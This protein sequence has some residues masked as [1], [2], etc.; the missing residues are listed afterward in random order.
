MKRVPREYTVQDHLDAARDF[1]YNISTNPQVA[2]ERREMR[3]RGS[4]IVE[5]QTVGIEIGARALTYISDYENKSVWGRL[6]G[7]AMLNSSLYMFRL[8]NSQPMSRHLKLPALFDDSGNFLD[9]GE[10]DRSTHESLHLLAKTSRDYETVA[11]E[12]K[13]SPKRT[14]MLARELGN[15]SMRLGIFGQDFYENDGEAVVMEEVRDAE[16]D[17]HQQIRSLAGQIG[18]N[19]SVAQLRAE[20]TPFSAHIIQSHLYTIDVVGAFREAISDFSD[21]AGY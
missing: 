11:Q 14:A 6:F 1:N 20:S 17:M 7:G 13:P 5:D 16:S 8:A 12:R 3:G 10:V 2:A 19:P 4:N 15:V 9:Q 18:V 21:Q